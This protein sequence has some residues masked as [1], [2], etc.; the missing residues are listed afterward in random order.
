MRL[1]TIKL[2]HALCE[3]NLFTTDTLGYDK[4]IESLSTLA[5]AIEAYG[6]DTESL[7]SIGE[8]GNATIQ[9]MIVGAHW[10][11]AHYSGGQNSAEYALGCATGTIYQPGCETENENDSTYQ[12]LVELYENK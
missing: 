8:F 6:G 10:F 3:R 7:W 12:A 5:D 4:T 1:K 2:I 11:S 9:D